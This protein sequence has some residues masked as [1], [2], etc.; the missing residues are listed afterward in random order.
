MDGDGAARNIRQRIKL[1]NC[2]RRERQDNQ[3]GRETDVFAFHDARP[4]RERRMKSRKSTNKTPL[5]HPARYRAALTAA[6]NPIAKSTAEVGSGTACTVTATGGAPR[7]SAAE[8]ST[9]LFNTDVPEFGASTTFPSSIDSP[10][11]VIR[12]I[13]RVPAPELVTFCVLA[14]MGCVIERLLPA[15]VT[16]NAVL[17]A[18]ERGAL[19][20]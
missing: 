4:L 14:V 5:A 11:A 7:F 3:S 16:V 2:W 20:V 15:G 17:S 8:P 13:V 6:A 18:S 1:R 19:I 12:R 10:A 9:R